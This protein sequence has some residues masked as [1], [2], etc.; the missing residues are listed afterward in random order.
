[1]ASLAQPDGRI[2][3]IRQTVMW[4]DEWRET[5]GNGRTANRTPYGTYP[6][7]RK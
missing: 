3:T 7:V 1:M 5:V 6:L 4:L 2:P